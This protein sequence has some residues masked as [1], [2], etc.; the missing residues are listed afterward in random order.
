MPKRYGPP[1]RD[2]ARKE[3]IGILELERF[4]EANLNRW[5]DIS[6][7]LDELQSV[8]YFNLVPER[9][10]H[11]DELLQAIAAT[12]PLAMEMT[13]WAR[14]V[15]YQYSTAPLSCAGSLQAYGG[16]FN[17]GVD[18]DPDVGMAPWPALYAGSDYETAYREKFQL[19]SNAAVNGLTPQ[20]L[21]LHPGQSHAT[22]LVN[23]HLN[24]VFDMRTPTALDAIARVLARIRMPP[25]ARD[26]R[27]KLSIPPGGVT[28]IQNGRNLY[29]VM[30]EHNWRQ[31]PV[32]FGLPAPTHIIAELLR[33]AEFEAVLY[34]SSKGAGDC[35]AIYPDKLWSGSF[36]ELTDAPPPQ[37]AHAR[38][39]EDSAPDLCGWDAVPRQFRPAI[40]SDARKR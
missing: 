10:R 15:S 17:A 9:R 36:V 23:G 28:M 20:E 29:K 18:L 34:R 25:R 19:A 16:R 1:Q 26:L 27:R 2:T 24:R 14:I 21:A 22:V 7:D 3:P 39:D 8:L 35:L 40:E 38:L 11:R 5:R 30:V 31:M 33:A 4:T 13:S 12:P 6:N 37:V 32:Q